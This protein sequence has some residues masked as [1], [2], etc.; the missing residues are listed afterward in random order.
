MGPFGL[1]QQRPGGPFTL[2]KLQAVEYG[3][4]VTHVEVSVKLNKHTVGIT[5]YSLED[6]AWRCVESLKDS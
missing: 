1:L 2:D 5:I 6:V 3:L 4:N